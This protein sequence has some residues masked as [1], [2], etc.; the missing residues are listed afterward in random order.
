[1]FLSIHAEGNQTGAVK[2]WDASH[3][4]ILEHGLKQSDPF[5]IPSGRKLCAFRAIPPKLHLE[6]GKVTLGWC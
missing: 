1:V 4:A 3:G 5:R 6:W 2:I